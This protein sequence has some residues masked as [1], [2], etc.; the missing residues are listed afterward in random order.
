M[1]TTGTIWGSSINDPLTWLSQNIIVANSISGTPIFLTRYLNY[2]IAFKSN[3]MEVFADTAN[4]PPGSPLS[5]VPNATSKIG[6]ANAY[7]VVNSG[8]SLF[9]MSYTQKNGYKIST[10]EG[11]N[12]I[13][14]STPSIER[15]I[16][17]TGSLGGNVYSYELK[18]SGHR[19]Y[20]LTL[21]A[22]NVTL[23]YDMDMKRWA[24]WTWL[25]IQSTKSSTLSYANGLVTATV[26]AHGYLDG[27]LVTI[28]GANQTAY[29]GTFTI[30]YIDANTF[31]YSITTSPVTPA[32]GTI[33][34]A[35]YTEG[36][37]PFVTYYGD[38]DDAYLLHESTGVIYKVDPTLF[39]DAGVPISVG[40]R[41][42]LFDGGN[43]DRKHISKVEII[44]DKSASTVYFRY[45]DDDYQTY[46]GYRPV[47]MSSVRSQLRRLGSTRRRAFE[48]KHN[49]NTDF[50][51]EAIEIEAD[52]GME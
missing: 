45:T 10:L 50:R 43:T 6:C 44:G 5:L 52:K 34:S 30:F 39:Q 19:F 3:S 33:T 14:V 35:G 48:L 25:T 27:S 24:K 36:Y 11:V 9:Y 18:V 23:V 22:I 51:A 37:M 40:A 38:S 12:S 2:I 4:P 1:D 41:T 31:S 7:T 42:Q 26:N 20:V 29:N 15:I 47:S 49:D 16:N 32:T 13:P 8:D 21:T 46:C 17:Q 28:A